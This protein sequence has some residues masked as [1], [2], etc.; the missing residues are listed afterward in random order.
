[1]PGSGL[2][3]AGTYRVGQKQYAVVLWVV[4]SS[5]MHQFKEI[6]LLESFL[7]FQKDVHCILIVNC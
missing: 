4:T 6:P 3:H 7:N 1:L 5:M 2:E